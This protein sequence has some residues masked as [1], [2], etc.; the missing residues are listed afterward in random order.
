MKENTLYKAIL[1][2]TVDFDSLSI[3]RMELIVI[4]SF[5]QKIV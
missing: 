4:L 1:N 2:T 5:V 3:S